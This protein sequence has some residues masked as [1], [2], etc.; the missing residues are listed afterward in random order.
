MVGVFANLQDSLNEVTSYTNK[1]DI[2]FPM[3]IDHEQKI[4]HFSLIATTWFPGSCL[5]TQ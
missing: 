5:G 2:T 3:L 4:G 1:A